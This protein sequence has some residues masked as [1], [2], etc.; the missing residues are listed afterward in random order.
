RSLT[1]IKAYSLI[2]D[3]QTLPEAYKRFLLSEMEYNTMAIMAQE[4]TTLS[5]TAGDAQRSWDFLLN[6]EKI[7]TPLAYTSDTYL[8]TTQWNQGEPYNKFLPEISGENVISGCVNVAMAQVMKYHNYPAA[9]TGVA[10]FNWNGQELKTVL[11]RTCNWE[12]MP[13]VLTPTQPDYK[14]DEIALLI[15]D[16]AIVNHTDFSLTDSSAFLNM[17]AWIENFGYSN[18]MRSL[19]ND[20]IA[21]FFDTL[22]GEIDAERPVLLSFPGHM[23]VA[24]GYS[25]DE[26][27]REIHVNMGWGGHYDD[28]YFLDQ[29][30]QAGDHTYPPDLTIYYNIKPCSG[31]YCFVNLESEDS[32]D[33]VN[34]TGKFDYDTDIDRYDLYLKG[35]TA[36]SGDRGYSNQAFYIS[37]YDSG[38]V[39]VASSDE[40]VTVNLSADRYTVR[41]SLLNELGFCYSYDD[42]TDYVVAISTDILTDAEKTAIESSLDIAPVINSSLNDILLNSSNP[43]VRKILIDARDENGDALNLDISN[44]NHSAVQAVLVGNILELSPVA[45]AS[46]IASKVTVR[47]S[48]NNKSIEE[49]FV[50][51]VLDEDIS[52][53]KEFFVTGVFEN[54]D[55]FNTHKVILDGACGIGYTGYSAQWFYTSV[56]GTSENVIVPPVNCEI[57]QTFESGIYLLGASLKENPGG[58]GSY[59]LYEQGVNDQYRLPIR[60]PDADDSVDNIAGILGI[61][62]SGTLGSLY[63]LTVSRVGTGSGAVISSPPGIDCGFDCSEAYNQDVQVTLTAIPDPDSSFTG[64]SGT[65]CSGTGDCTVTMDTEKNVAA[66]FALIGDLDQNGIVDLSDALTALQVYTGINP[67]STIHK[68]SDV[69][70]DGRIGLQELIYILQK[71]SGLR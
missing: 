63:F 67:V 54:Q 1:P 15:R 61:D 39:M 4:R 3:F 41:V 24:D 33:G 30:V 49:S 28:Y 59:Y 32:I 65:E 10:S 11:Y 9:G 58:Y 29:T 68:E 7:R 12:N 70:S 55:D 42:K 36:I 14:V 53:G 19:T 57:S 47:A 21:L 2:G 17:D 38:N 26:T 34:I 69:N 62:L 22:R 6:F 60:C 16:L 56:M 51:M 71:V 35:D 18:S 5:V 25:S 45:G 40:P 31:A 50:V 23:V 46:G 8:L 20:D 48:A 66:I 52:F 43:T 44:T 13:D 37:I 27:G 64:W